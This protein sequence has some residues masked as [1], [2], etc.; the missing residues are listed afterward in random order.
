[1]VNN[2]LHKLVLRY[3]LCVM[4]ATGAVAPAHARV[5]AVP[6]DSHQSTVSGGKT[7]P[8]VKFANIWADDKGATHIS[9]CRFEGLEYKSY[10]PPSAPQWIG[11]SPDEI[12]SVAYAV[13][14]PGYIGTWHAAP[15]PQWVITLSGKWSVETTDGSKL[16]QAAGEML[17]DTDNH[18]RPR[19]DD[20]RVG[21]VSRTEGDVPNV[22]LIIKLK[23]NAQNVRTRSACDN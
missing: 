14:P 4:A 23:D 3:G 11:V 16:E 10:A 19:P 21:H 9:Y 8:P 20:D 6:A 13:L 18:S 17:L 12:E 15:G 1:M 2:A 7:Q 5:Q 22:Q